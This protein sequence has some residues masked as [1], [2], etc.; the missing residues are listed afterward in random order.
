MGGELLTVKD[1]SHRNAL[2][3]LTP[4]IR[5]GFQ[6][7]ECSRKPKIYHKPIYSLVFA[8]HGTTANTIHLAYDPSSSNPS[9]PQ[10]ILENSHHI[11]DPDLYNTPLRSIHPEFNKQSSDTTKRVEIPHGGLCRFGCYVRVPVKSI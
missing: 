2:L 3:V 1:D 6:N 11:F 4:T 5:P 8:G 10:R 7:A 9:N